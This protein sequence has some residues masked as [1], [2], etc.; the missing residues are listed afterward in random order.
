MTYAS[1]FPAVGDH[2]A[3]D[4]HGPVNRAAEATLSRYKTG[5]DI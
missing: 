3:H 5:K 2:P 4:H 1:L